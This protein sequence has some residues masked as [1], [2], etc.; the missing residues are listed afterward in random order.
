MDGFGDLKN[1]AKEE[2]NVLKKL[3]RDNIVI[4]LEKANH[5]ILSIY[6]GTT[7]IQDSISTLSNLQKLLLKILIISLTMII[8]S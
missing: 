3:I 2:S 7:M 6:N 8:L 5:N 4:S 1:I